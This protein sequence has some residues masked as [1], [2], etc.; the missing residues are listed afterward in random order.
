MYHWA[1]PGLITVCSLFFHLYT[2]NMPL[3]KVIANIIFLYIDVK[4]SWL[5][6]LSAPSMKL[7]NYFSICKYIGFCTSYLNMFKPD[8][9]K[10]IRHTYL[11]VIKYVP[12]SLTFPFMFLHLRLLRQKT[13]H[14][15]YNFVDSF[16]ISSNTEFFIILPRANISNPMSSA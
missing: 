16:W 8:K 4:G 13:F 7:F 1:M 10:I 15:S 2:L 14:L 6:E 12:K 9:E 5:N 3:L 11:F